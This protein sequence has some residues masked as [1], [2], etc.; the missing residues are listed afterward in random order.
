MLSTLYG[1]A[2]V[3]PGDSEL[4]RRLRHGH[5]DRSDST[6]TMYRLGVTNDAGVIYRLV[7]V[8]GVVERK[9][10]LELLKR[11]GYSQGEPQPERGLDAVFRPALHPHES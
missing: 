2:E 5:T 4:L 1:Q 11:M 8:F 6:A 7:I 9:E 3:P 10:V